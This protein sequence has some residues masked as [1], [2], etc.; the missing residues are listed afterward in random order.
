LFFYCIGAQLEPEPAIVSSSQ[1]IPLD[2]IEPIYV[3]K[4]LIGETFADNH[5]GSAGAVLGTAYHE[6]ENMVYSLVEQATIIDWDTTTLSASFSFVKTNVDGSNLQTVLELFHFNG[7]NITSSVSISTGGGSNI[8]SITQSTDHPIIYYIWNGTFMAYDTATQQNQILT[9]QTDLDF[10]YTISS[11]MCYN[12]DLWFVYNRQLGEDLFNEG[13]ALA[14]YNPQ[15]GTFIVWM[16]LEDS[17]YEIDTSFAISGSIYYGLSDT[18][19][20]MEGNRNC[21][22]EYLYYL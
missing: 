21:L 18:I 2:T 12:D 15:N 7:S 19:R 3:V 4:E 16:E 13:W 10:N 14:S 1:R 11:F 20:K 6:K 5:T 22:K 8:F 9:I 17:N